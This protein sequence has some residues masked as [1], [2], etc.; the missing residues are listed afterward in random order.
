MKELLFA[1][2]SLDIGGIEK[3][4]VTLTNYLQKRG[5]QITII[6]EKKQGIFLKELNKDIKVIEYRPDESKNILKRKAKNLVKRFK[7]MIKYKNKFDFSASS[8]F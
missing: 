4:L 7:F 5:Y 3:S 8:S 2:Y 1:A 6:L